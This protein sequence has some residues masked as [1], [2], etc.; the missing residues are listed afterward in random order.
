MLLAILHLALALG[1]PVLFFGFPVEAKN[2][3]ARAAGPITYAAAQ[4]VEDFRILRSALEEGHSGI[5]GYTPKAELDLIFDRAEKALNRPMTCVEFY[6]LIAPVVAAVKCGHTSV[7]LPD[8]LQTGP[9][10]K[11]PIL[12][13]QV[14]VFDGKVY[15]F[16]DFS[17]DK[18]ALAGQEIKSI[19]GIRADVIMATMIKA[20]PGDG[21][22]QSSRL[23]RLRGRIFGLNLV[24]LLGLVAPYTV[25]V[26]DSRNKQETVRVIQGKLPAQILAEARAR[27][28]QDQVRPKPPGLKFLDSDRIALMR[29]HQFSDPARGGQSNDLKRFLK[30]SFVAIKARGTQALILDLRD[31]GGGEDELGKDL[32]SYFVAEPFQYY[33]DLVINAREFRFQKYTGDRE[34]LPA[35]Y[36]ERQPNGKYRM[37]KHPNWGTNQPSKPHFAG[38][39]FALINGGS[40]STTSEFL[41]HLHDRKRA[42]FVGEESGGGYY[43]NTSGPEA[44]VTLPNTKLNLSLPLMT[45]YLH[46]SRGHAA[47][48]GVVPD[49]PVH[50]SIQ[51]LIEGQDKELTAAL[52]QARS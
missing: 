20:T 3:E 9:T 36:V 31:N 21:D 46:V 34:P 44:L 23:W 10:S 45:Y 50:Y 38:K 16:R 6:R 8:T 27:F 25:S 49:I 52:K 40:F 29:I 35:E 17:D 47:A 33:D 4:L 5:Y 28:P 32:L 7:R 42:I 26:L 39:V 24:D 11:R 2:P 51:E 37:T 13:L 48:H 19:N 15:V 12:P 1:Q 22:V 30:A 41:S 43:G 14:K 18:G